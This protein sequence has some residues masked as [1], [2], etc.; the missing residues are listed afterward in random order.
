MTIA[1]DIPYLSRA[2]DKLLLPPDDHF[3]ASRILRFTHPFAISSLSLASFFYIQPN[4]FM[5]PTLYDTNP[6]GSNLVNRFGEPCNSAAEPCFFLHADM[7]HESPSCI[8][9]AH[10]PEVETS[11][12]TVYWA[13]DSTGDRKDG[14]LVRF[15]FQ[16][17]HGPGSMDH[18]VAAIR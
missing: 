10:D 9:I 3:T 14:E 2:L 4:F 16:Q 17:P 12:G 15:D 8:G 13:F 5:G 18:S 11:Y 1:V 7:L 6:V